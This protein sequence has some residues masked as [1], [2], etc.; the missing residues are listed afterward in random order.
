MIER[1]NG[2]SLDGGDKSS[3]K[4]GRAHLLFLL[5]ARVLVQSGGYFT[6][7]ATPLIINKYNL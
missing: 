1:I 7:L 3:C 5:G 4:E 6:F 2:R